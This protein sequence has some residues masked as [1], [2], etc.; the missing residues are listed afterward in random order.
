LSDLEELLFDP[1][2]PDY[3][4]DPH[5]KLRAM[6]ERA[7]AYWWPQGPAWIFTRYADVVIVLRD[8]RFSADP[9]QWE[10][11]RVK[12]LEDR[13]AHERLLETMLFSLNASD[14]ARIRRLV[15]PAFSVR[16][17]EQLRPAITRIVRDTLPPTGAFDLYGEFAATLPMAVMC[18]LLGVPPEQHAAFL[19]LGA[20]LFRGTNA[21]QSE[22]EREAVARPIAEGV[23]ILRSL[24]DERRAR[25]GDDL[26]SALVHAS[27]DDQL[28]DHDEL[29]GLVASLVAAGM[30]TTIQHICYAAFHLMAAPAALQLVRDEPAL[31]PNALDEVLRYDFFARTG[32]SR[33]ATEDL[34]LGGVT[35]KR[36]QLVFPSLT[37]AMRD[38][39]VFPDPDRFDVRRDQSRSIAFGGGIYQCLGAHLARVEVEIAIRELFTRYPRL[40]LAGSPRRAPE[41]FFRSFAALP[42]REV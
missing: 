30:D 5:S 21:R 40:R 17:V 14:H 16:A 34:E 19:E 28:L 9:A 32:P 18:H 24:I 7:P 36:G 25:P 8:R 11:H 12:P 35:V 33:Y 10:H 1:F 6:R 31:L 22:A 38:P 27:A 20:A 15:A 29:I 41:P 39:D 2:A 42:V 26:L 37:A 23:A 13:T 3:E 4:Q